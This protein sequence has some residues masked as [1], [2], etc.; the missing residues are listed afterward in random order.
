M[1]VLISGASGDIGAEVVRQLAARGATVILSARDPARAAATAARLDG[2]V[3]ALPA[4]LD[5]TDQASVDDAAT[6]LARDPGALDV[7][8][9]NAAA[10]VGWTETASA[11]DLDAAHA[12][13]ET[14]LFGAWRLTNA[15]LLL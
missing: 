9:N 4:G 1:I 13:V 14:N 15:M 5:V 11:A 12:V 7:L 3:R 8:V 6:A 10:F 2:D